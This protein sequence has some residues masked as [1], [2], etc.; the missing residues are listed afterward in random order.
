[1]AT[2]TRAPPRRT[3]LYAAIVIVVIIVVATV[4]FALSTGGSTTTTSSTKTSTSQVT[5]STSSCTGSSTS[6]TITIV[7]GPVLVGQTGKVDAEAQCPGGGTGTHVIYSYGQ[8]INIA[9]TVP[10]DLT[11][12]AIGT[13]LDGNPQNTNPWNVTAS[14]HTYYESFGGAGQSVLVTNGPHD[15]FATVTFSDNSTATSNVVFFTV[16]GSPGG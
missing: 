15:I 7:T 3:P 8:Q 4:G 1:M 16:T 10:S 14:G 9:V 6:Q 11:P 5:T 2:T 13:T 12:I